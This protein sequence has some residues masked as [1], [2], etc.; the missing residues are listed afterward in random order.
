MNS[1][2]NPSAKWETNAQI[3]ERN[4]F[5]FVSLRFLRN[6]K[7]WIVFTLFDRSATQTPSIYICISHTH[8]HLLF[9]WR[10]MQDWMLRRQQHNIVIIAW[11]R[12]LPMVLFAASAAAARLYS[13]NRPSVRSFGRSKIFAALVYLPTCLSVCLSVGR[14]ICCASNDE[15]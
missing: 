9:H 15:W 4:L 13:A 1:V 8:I 11:M 3:G 10:S 5:F 6:Q 14:R 12:S 2:I 7:K